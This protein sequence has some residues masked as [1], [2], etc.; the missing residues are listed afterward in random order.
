MK[1][2]SLVRWLSM[3]GMTTLVMMET[4]FAA[5]VHVMIS[6]LSGAPHGIALATSSIRVL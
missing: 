1:P 6:S 2:R 3:I 5:D 4:A